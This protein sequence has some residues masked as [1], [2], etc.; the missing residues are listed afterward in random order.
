MERQA[1][2]NELQEALKQKINQ[3]IQDGWKHY[4]HNGQLIETA[5]EIMARLHKFEPI[6]SIKPDDPEPIQLK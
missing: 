1:R 6:Q 5:D 2:V 3:A 4:D